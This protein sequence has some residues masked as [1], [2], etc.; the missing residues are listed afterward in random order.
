MGTGDFAKREL[1]ATKR[2]IGVSVLEA[3]KQRIAVAFDLCSR[4]YV[5][6]SAGKDSTVM[7]HLVAD[8]A[9]KRGRT[10]GVLLIDLEAQYELT[11]DHAEAMRTEYADCTEWYWVCLP[12]ALRN[13]VSVYQ[14]QWVCW[15]DA[16]EKSWVRQP[17][18]D[19]ITD[20]NA[21]P[22]FVAGMEFEEFVPEFGKWYS[23]GER[24]ACFVGIRTD[25]SL[26]RFRTI[27]SRSKVRLD[28][29]PYTTLVEENL[30]NFYP[31]YDWRTED[32]WLWHAR[33][34]TKRHNDSSNENLP[35]IR[36]RS[37]PRVVAIPPNRAEDVGQ[38]CREGEWSQQR[39]NVYPRVRQH[40]RL[41]HGVTAARPY[42]AIV[43]DHAAAIPTDENR[44]PLPG[45]N[46]RSSQ[47]V[48]GSWIRTWDT[49]RGRH[50]P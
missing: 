23:Q 46:R 40:D 5:S 3:A 1:P 14:P 10:I 31:I 30:Y 47:V 43:C 6:F 22:F 15:D 44:A 36:R 35:A 45:Q 18:A 24:T 11:I 34:P 9:R 39:R 33:N 29:L 2:P 27:A 21:F 4:V 12:I 41:S 32:L 13:A 38:G 50:S 19:A 16:A 48:D 37:A 25:E 17:P 8:E 26:N 28:G 42:V 7:L 20:V 49:R